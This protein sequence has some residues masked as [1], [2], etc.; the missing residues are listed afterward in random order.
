MACER[1]VIIEL[2]AHESRIVANG[3][4]GGGEPVRLYISQSVG[5]FDSRSL[6]ERLLK[7]AK[8]TL[9]EDGVP[10]PAVYVDTTLI[11]SLGNEYNL[12]THYYSTLV[13]SEGHD[14]RLQV[15]QAG[16][17]SATA[18]TSI[19]EPV[20]IQAMRFADNVFL[21]Q[22]G[23]PQFRFSIEFEDPPGRGDYY[24][25]TCRLSAYL[26]TLGGFRL[27]ETLIFGNEA[28]IAERAYD[29]G[30]LLSDGGFDGQSVQ[31]DFYGSLPGSFTNGQNR[32]TALYVELRHVSP[33]YYEY[34]AD[35]P[36]HQSSQ[37]EQQGFF[38]R[39]PITV[40]S[41]V[42]G[43]YGIFAGYATFRDTLFQ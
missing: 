16:F 5:V 34:Q 40:F 1:V 11:D 21:D 13:P 26:D 28:N 12:P 23:N 6:E 18:E 30:L 31:R 39:D 24:H 25:L 32:W 41:N 4:L 37:S 9:F 36:A 38:R 2:P 15:T 29:G 20:A 7:D 42:E 35:F 43:G 33:E 17:E 27:E 19:P 8:V 3:V 22:A 10:Y 14:Y